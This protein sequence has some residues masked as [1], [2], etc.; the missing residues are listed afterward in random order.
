[1][2]II[3][4]VMF[5]LTLVFYTIHNRRKSKYYFESRL[6]KIIPL[7]PIFIISYS[8]YFVILIFGFISLWN[9]EFYLDFIKMIFFSALINSLFWLIFPNGAKREKITKKGFFYD[10][11]KFLRKIDMDSNACPSAHVSHTLIVS[12]WLLRLFPIYSALIY[13][14]CFLII[15][16]V[17]FTKQHNIIDIFGGIFSFLISYAVVLL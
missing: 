10:S 16:S 14:V 15:I 9:T 8:F 1:M 5:L 13:L 2:K 12:F 7:F 11:I 6:D 17:V 4:T 3:Y